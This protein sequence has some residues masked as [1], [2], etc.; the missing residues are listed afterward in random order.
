MFVATERDLKALIGITAGD[1]YYAT[2]QT[3]TGTGANEACLLAF[4]PH[5]KGLIASN[6]FFGGADRSGAPEPDRS[7]RPCERRTTSH[8]TPSVGAALD[9]DPSSGGCFSSV[10]RP[11]PDSKPVRGD[12]PGVQGRGVFVGA[13]AISS[14]YAY[15]IDIAASR[16]DLVTASSA[17]AIMAAPGLAITFVRKA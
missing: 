17:K 11:A 4:K 14:A 2:V 3:S 1:D 5:G 10:T 6:G 8:S 12:R 7:R 13:D 15:P 9:A 16:I